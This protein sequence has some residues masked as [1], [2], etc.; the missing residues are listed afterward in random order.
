MKRIEKQYPE[1]AE[2]TVDD[3]AYCIKGMEDDLLGCPLNEDNLRN[4]L[5]F[6]HRLRNFIRRKNPKHPAASSPQQPVFPLC[7]YTKLSPQWK[8]ALVARGFPEN[9]TNS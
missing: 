1:F 5:V 4:K 2:A 6:L 9:H 7:A 8:A 3:L